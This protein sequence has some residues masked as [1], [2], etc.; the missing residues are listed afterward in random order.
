[1]ELHREGPRKV[2]IEYNSCFGCIHHDYRMIHSGMH[3][4]YSNNC[5]HP[6][7]EKA[8]SYMGN[9]GEEDKTPDWCP[10]VKNNE[11]NTNNPR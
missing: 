5:N 2:K 7:S 6:K 10:I 11:G 8:F 3:P 4:L 1:M 9:I